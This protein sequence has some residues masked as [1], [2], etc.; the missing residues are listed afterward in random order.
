MEIIKKPVPTT[1]ASGKKLH[2]EKC[3]RMKHLPSLQS[4]AEMI[5]R[6]ESKSSPFC[7]SQRTKLYTVPMTREPSLPAHVQQGEYRCGRCIA[8][9]NGSVTIS[10]LTIV[11]SFKSMRIFML[12]W[13]N[14]PTSVS[15]TDT[16][17]M[18]WI[19]QF[20]SKSGLGKN[21]FIVTC[22]LRVSLT[23]I[24]KSTPAPHFCLLLKMMQNLYK[25]GII[26]LINV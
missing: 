21:A 9:K 4:M 3:W 20:H 26:I 22:A 5:F 16:G 10:S 8:I 19:S 18:R 7:L 2:P 11:P 6:P 12:L 25:F 13:M 1:R 15:I 17:A 23:A 14:L 24:E